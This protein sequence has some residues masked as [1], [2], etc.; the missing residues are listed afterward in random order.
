MF[1]NMLKHRSD[2]G[3]LRHVTGDPLRLQHFRYGRCALFV[4]YLRS[5]V[6]MMCPCVCS[7]DLDTE[8]GELWG[9]TPQTY[10]LVGLINCAL[11][12]SRSWEDV[13]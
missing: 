6:Y 1:E 10:S 8:T 9:N 3:L 11:R 2:A 7:E 12:L 4:F 13:L 5:N